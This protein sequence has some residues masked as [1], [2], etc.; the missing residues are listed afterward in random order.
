MAENI[1]RPPIEDPAEDSVT[2]ITET[3]EE[4]VTPAHSRVSVST[5]VEST[6]RRGPS[7]NVIIVALVAALALVAL[8]AFFLWPRRQERAV[9][10]ETP[11]TAQAEHAGEGG[12]EHGD[13]HSQEGAIEV[14]D[15]T[16][17]LVG[18][19][20]EPAAKGEIEDTTA[21]TGRVLVA[22][23]AQAVVG[24]KTDGRV[25]SVS[26]E[27]GQRV[28]AGQTVV[29][30]DSPQVADLRGQLIEA[31]SRLRLAEAARARTARSENRAAVIQAKNKMDLA[32]ATLERKRRLSELGV[33][34]GREVQEADM[35]FK[36]AK[37]E[38]DYQ[39]SIQATRGQ[40][41]AAGE[42]EQAQAT[43]ARISQS[44]AALGAGAG[45][46]GGTISIASPIAGT[47]VDRHVSIGEAVTQGKEMLTVMNL[48]SVIVEAQLPESQAGRVRTGQRMIARVPGEERAF[49]GY[50]QSIGETV[51]PVKRTVG[52]RARVTNLG[53]H[54]KHEMAVEVRLVTG[55]RKDALMVPASALV[56]DE[57]LKVVYVKEGERYERR[58]VTVGSVTYQWA[59]ILSGVEEGEEVVTAGAY[60]LRNM[61]KGGGE[62]GGHH[63]D[64]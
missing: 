45:G 46:T 54:L 60:Q 4:T 36:N 7:R 19:K 59:E 52:V 30:I 33:A 48:A 50:V 57:G 9:A 20:T 64:H 39:S 16:A 25:V 34:A 22:P 3:K 49:E 29:V 56:D 15:E 28:G 8:L 61:Q 32:Q 55:G 47:V 1:T 42:V 6:G 5:E 37:A 63:D 13:E 53:T 35:E 58:P 26:A 27:P 38:Y 2:R 24:A 41:E 21:T 11:P 17:E 44:L 14:S 12:G 31:R 62:E 40:Q 10:V 23:N 18:I 51:D 43:V